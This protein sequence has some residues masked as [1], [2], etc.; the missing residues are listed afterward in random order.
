MGRMH[1]NVIIFFQ[2]CEHKKKYRL[3]RT[4]VN[5]NLLRLNG[6][7]NFGD[8]FSE[9]RVSLR[10]GV[11]EPGLLKLLRCASLQGKQVRDGHGLTV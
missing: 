11:S 7:I 10:F 8:L 4:G 2:R 6:L 3:F 9:R 1:N 5:E